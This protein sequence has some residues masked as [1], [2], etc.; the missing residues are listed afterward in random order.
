MA[1]VMSGVPAFVFIGD[2]SHHTLC[3][4]GNV[5]TSTRHANGLI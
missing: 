2:G 3:S 4:I 5:V 1:G